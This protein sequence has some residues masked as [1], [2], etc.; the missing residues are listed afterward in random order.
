MV[1][2]L[3]IVDVLDTLWQTLSIEVT[4]FS[5]IRFAANWIRMTT[6]ENREVTCSSSVTAEVPNLFAK[7]ILNKK[8]NTTHSTLSFPTHTHPLSAH[9]RLKHDEI[10][11]SP[12]PS[13]PPQKEMRPSTRRARLGRAKT[14]NIK[15]VSI[16]PLN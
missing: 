4:R 6:W 7:L 16:P 13:R 9:I 12:T 11:T 3:V 14:Q 10:V 8:E 5:L 2:R 15:L 1:A